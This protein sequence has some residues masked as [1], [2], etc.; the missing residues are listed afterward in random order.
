MLH[1]AHTTSGQLKRKSGCHIKRMKTAGPQE[2]RV[3]PGLLPWLGEGSQGAIPCPHHPPSSCE[4]CG[5][6]PRG[7]PRLAAPSCAVRWEPGQRRELPCRAQ[8]RPAY[9]AQRAHPAPRT[10]QPAART[11]ASL[12]GP[13][14]VWRWPRAGT[15]QEQRRSPR[16]SEA[17]GGRTP[18]SPPR[19]VNSSGR[20]SGHT[21]IPPRA[22]RR[23][24][25]RPPA[26]PLPG[27]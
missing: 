24:A 15:A 18:S 11:P 27:R 25:S 5:R 26:G 10:P 21:A 16:L 12:P 2:S 8:P 22:P 23:P 4:R 9:N 20:A 7:S 19:R 3:C 17:P 6:A 1:H 13:G 14:R